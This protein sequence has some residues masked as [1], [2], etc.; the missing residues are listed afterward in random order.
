[1]KS[2]SLYMSIKLAS[3]SGLSASWREGGFDRILYAKMEGEG[4]GEIVTRVT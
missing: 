1:M 4:L 3:F 2:A